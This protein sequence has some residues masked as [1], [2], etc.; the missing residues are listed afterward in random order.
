MRE[1]TGRALQAYKYPVTFTLAHATGHAEAERVPRV[2]SPAAAHIGAHIIRYRT[3]AGRTQDELAAG[4]G[5]D[6]SNIRAYENGR[7]MPSV[8]TLVRI[9]EALG[10]LPADLLQG[11]ELEMFMAPPTDQRRRAV[12]SP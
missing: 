5:I 1:Q 10:V 2:A 9:A 7:A 8:H 6:S 3:G 11:L 4:T 12:Q